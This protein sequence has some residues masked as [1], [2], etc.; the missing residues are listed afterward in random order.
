MY[1]RGNLTFET[2]TLPAIAGVAETLVKDR[3]DNYLAGLWESELPHAL[4]W[5]SHVPLNPHFGLHGNTRPLEFIAPTWSWA[6]V[7]GPVSYGL[8]GCPRR[9][10]VATVVTASC[11][12]AGPNPFGRILG[13]FLELETDVARIPVNQLAVNLRFRGA[14]KA[15]IKRVPDERFNW[16]LSLDVVAELFSAEGDFCLQCDSE[17]IVC[18]LID[19]TPQR[20]QDGLVTRNTGFR[21]LALLPR[22]DGSYTRLGLVHG[23]WGTDG[24][25]HRRAQFP[26]RLVLKIV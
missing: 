3:C 6:S 26:E 19:L 1:T 12:A 2:D 24:P 13:A 16:N 4:G 20:D 22:N 25:M 18:A 15:Y 8:P 17:F 7:K 23:Y 5:C 10:P 21:A 14:G 9:E 11:D